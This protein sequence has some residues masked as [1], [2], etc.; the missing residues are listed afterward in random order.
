MRIQA[1]DLR[2]KRT[3]LWEVVPLHSPWTMF[4]DVTNV[5]N[6]K[7]VYCPTGNDD[8]LA[9]SARKLNSISVEL[10]EKIVND[11]KCMDRLKM[12][13]LYKDGEPLAHPQFTKFVSILKQ[14]N[15]TDKIW[16]KTNGELLGRHQDLATCGLDML[17]ISVPHVTEIGIADTIGKKLNYSKYVEGIK[18]LYESDRTFEMS[19]KIADTGLTDSEKD[20]FYN[21]F[22]HI[23]EYISI[24]GLHGWSAS[25]V[26]NMQIFDSGTF[27]GNPF[28][29]KK[30]C[31]LV[32]YMMTINADGTVSVCN[33]DWGYNHKL[34]DVTKDSLMDIWNGNKFKDFRM[35]HL[36]GNKARDKSCGTCQYVNAL[37]D[38]VD[39]HADEM[40]RRMI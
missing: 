13:N 26:K 38:N 8:M 17:G 31:P 6:F 4:I 33:D 37:P 35:M 14:S 32:F 9:G 19:I 18:K 2:G 5:C 1:K 29:E 30:V 3:N 20:K 21:D 16:V 36:N 24:E 11:M 22:E 23:C 7:C 40:K 25:D 39:D 10:F 34:G 12:V 15:V 27:D 28:D